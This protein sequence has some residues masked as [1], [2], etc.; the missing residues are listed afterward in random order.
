MLLVQGTERRLKGSAVLGSACRDDG[1]AFG[2]LEDMKNDTQ[3]AR[4]LAHEIGHT[5][6]MR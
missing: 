2:M 6:G 1:Y 3:T 4:L 5:L